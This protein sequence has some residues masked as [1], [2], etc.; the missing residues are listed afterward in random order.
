MKNQGRTLE[1]GPIDRMDHQ[2]SFMCV[3][4]SVGEV[5]FFE[6][7]LATLSVKG[8][9]HRCPLSNMKGK[10][11]RAGIPSQFHTMQAPFAKKT[12]SVGSVGIQLLDLYCIVGISCGICGGGRGEGRGSLLFTAHFWWGPYFVIVCSVISNSLI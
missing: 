4:V 10:A 5:G 7:P 6:S 2:L 12:P 8:K 3:V 11:K 1:Y 9:L